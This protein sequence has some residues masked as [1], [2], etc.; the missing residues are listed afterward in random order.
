MREQIKNIQ[1]NGYGW[2]DYKLFGYL[3]PVLVAQMDRLRKQYKIGVR[4]YASSR[5]LSNDTVFIRIISG[6]RNA[7]FEPHVDSLTMEEIEHLI[8]KALK[9]C[10]S[11]DHWYAFEKEWD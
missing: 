9:D 5:F 4:E 6:L 1:I 10:A 3:K 11:A 8:N 7:N 2:F